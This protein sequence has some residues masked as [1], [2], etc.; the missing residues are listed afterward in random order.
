MC[1]LASLSTGCTVIWRLWERHPMS[2]LVY[3]WLADKWIMPLSTKNIAL[4][5]VPPASPA[6]HNQLVLLRQS[7]ARR[8]PDL[9]T[10]VST[11]CL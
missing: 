7:L 1:I 6:N 10:H 5:N 9:F 11:R 8:N 2:R 4:A 3:V